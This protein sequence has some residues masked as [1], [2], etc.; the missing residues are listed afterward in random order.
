MIKIGF[1]FL[2]KFNFG[3]FNMGGKMDTC[4]DDWI[5]KDKIIIFYV[6][7]INKCILKNI[8]KMLTGATHPRVFEKI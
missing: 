7:I 8:K 6:L 1:G 4:M 5:Q 2:V 3:V